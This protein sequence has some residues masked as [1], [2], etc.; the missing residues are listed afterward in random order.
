MGRSIHNRP[1]PNWWSV[2]PARCVGQPT[3]AEPMERHPS[4]KILCLAP[5][6]VFVSFL[7]PFFTFFCLTFLSFPSFSFIALK[8]SSS[9]APLALIK[10]EGFFNRSLFIRASRPTHV[11]NF[12]M[13]L[14]LHHYMH[15]YDLSFGQ[16]GLPGSCAYP[17]VPDCSA[18]R[19]REHLCDCYC[20]VSRMCTSDWVKPKASVLKGIFDRWNKDDLFINFHV[21]PDAFSAF[22]TIRT[23]TFGHA[24]PAKGTLNGT[25]LS[26]RCFL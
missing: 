4:L 26:G 21:P 8:G 20:R 23:C 12:R 9:D 22:Y 24:S 16:A 2:P 13:Y 25:I 11:S 3:R 19:S 14:F 5:D 15:R 18:R 1:S 6:S 10:P 17:Y 7:C